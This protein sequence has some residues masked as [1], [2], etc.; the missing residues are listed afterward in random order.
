MRRAAVGSALEGYERNHQVKRNKIM[1]DYNEQ[2]C[3]FDLHC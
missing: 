2:V 3:L 1:K